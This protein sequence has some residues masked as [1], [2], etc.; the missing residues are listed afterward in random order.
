MKEL[1][2]QAI[3]PWNLPLTVLLG[4]VIVF[5]SLKILTGADFASGDADIDVDG[6]LEHAGGFSSDLM[7]AVNAGAVPLTIVL[8]VL[9][10]ALWMA[11]ILLNYYLNPEKKWFLN[12][13]LLLAS[14]VIAV[15]ATKIITQPLVPVMRRLKSAEDA[16]PVIGETG[17]VRSIEIDSRYGQVEV[18]RPQGAPAILN[19]RLLPDIE[20]VPRGTTVAVVSYDQ[21]AGVYL[22]KPISTE[23]NTLKS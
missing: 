3:L 11:S 13:G 10:L 21:A 15:V 14:L 23:S 22:V 9:I 18:R 5:W 7:R 20:P 16:A 12:A 1:W 17:V 4:L 19:S 8:S 2:E 6:G